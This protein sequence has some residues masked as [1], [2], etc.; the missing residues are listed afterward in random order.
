MLSSLDANDCVVAKP[1]V[2]EML[3]VELVNDW[4][5]SPI[6]PQKF[7]ELALTENADDLICILFDDDDSMRPTSKRLD[8][9]DQSRG[10]RKL[11]QGNI[12]SKT[13]DI[14]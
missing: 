9:L 12:T 8:C 3:R 6:F 11:D 14:F 7:N 4:K 13:F 5:A 1:E 10:M 2:A